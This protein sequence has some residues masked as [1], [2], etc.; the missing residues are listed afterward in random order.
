MDV[1]ALTDE[2][3]KDY[4]SVN[5]KWRGF[6]VAI[7]LDPKKIVT[8]QE[9][10]ISNMFEIEALRELFFEKGIITPVE[11]VARFEKLDREKNAK[12]GR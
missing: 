11:F 7:P 3:I 1:E 12:V 4:R 10:A 5:P 9:L 2:F 6:T 8:V